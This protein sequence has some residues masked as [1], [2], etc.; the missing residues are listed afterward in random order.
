MRKVE[1]SCEKV[2]RSS[3]RRVALTRL[4]TQL[5]AAAG[6]PPD[7]NIVLGEYLAISENLPEM[8]KGKPAKI[9]AKKKY[10]FSKIGF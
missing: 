2:V 7:T 5:M 6:D 9:E 3:V 10:I 1:E 4:Y 8:N